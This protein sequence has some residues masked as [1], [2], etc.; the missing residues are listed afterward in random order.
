M[1]ILQSF[2]EV[3]AKFEPCKKPSKIGELCF[4]CV[5][6]KLVDLVLTLELLN[7]STTVDE[8]LLTCKERM[9]R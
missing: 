8:L 1:T 2:C 5:Y 6:V 7:T 9:A 3:I 4:S